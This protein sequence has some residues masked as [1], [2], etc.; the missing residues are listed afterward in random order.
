MSSSLPGH[1]ELPA[2][3]HDLKTYVGRVK[4][5][6]GITD[7]ST[8]F[9]GSTGLERAKQLV[10]EYKTGK[11]ERMS[12][13]LWRAKK[14]VDSTLHPDTG[15]PVFLPF[16]MSCFVFSNLIVTAGM[17]QP[18][19]STTGV[20]AWQVINQSLNVAINTANSNKSS[21][22]TTETLIKSYLIAVSASCSVA[23]G[24]NA[25]VPR[26]K[27]SVSTRNILSRLVPFAAVASAGALNTYLMRRG[28]ILS[29]IDVRP[30]LSEAEKS[31]L[32]AENKSE[33]DIPSLGKSQTAAKIAVYETAASRVFNSS[34][35]MVLPALALYH[36]QQKQAWYQNLLQKPWVKARPVVSKSIPI[37]INLGLIAITAFAALP[38]ALAAFPQQEEISAESLEPEFHGKGG[39]GGKVWFNRGL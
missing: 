32:Q 31:Q 24:L 8:L 23:L 17:L 33:R 37:G 25:M 6:I 27:V 1:R 19:L 21:P 2:S 22:M 34:P 18:G 14:I 35:T 28:E 36:I 38:L 13:D 3:Q 10:T 30:V 4:H 16:R 15:E 5:S 29:G 9:A 7:P 12:P 11:I 20:V 39:A 26:L